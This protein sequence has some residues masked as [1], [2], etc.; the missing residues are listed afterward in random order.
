LNLARSW[1]LANPSKKKSN[2]K[3]FLHNWFTRTQDN[4]GSKGEKP[5]NEKPKITHEELERQRKLFEAG[6]LAFPDG[7]KT[8]DGSDIKPKPSKT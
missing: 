3:K 7:R 2:Y 8:F 5:K 1:L 6:R 4:G